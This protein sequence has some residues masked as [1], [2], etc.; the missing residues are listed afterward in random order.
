MKNLIT[1]AAAVTAVVLVTTTIKVARISDNGEVIK[2]CKE[3]YNIVYT[4]GFFG[5]KAH[6]I[7][8]MQKFGPVF[9]PN[10]IED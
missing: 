10:R 7:S 5:P 8:N 3:L 1:T 4:E 2:N 9:N 6:C